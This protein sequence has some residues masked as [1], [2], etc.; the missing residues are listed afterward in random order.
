MGMDIAALGDPAFQVG[1][2]R[3]WV[4]DREFPD[5]MDYWDGNWLDVTAYCQYP[6]ANVW[7]QGTFVRTDELLD[8]LME[9]ERLHATLTGQAALNC[10]E[11]NLHVELL[12]LAHGQ[13]TLKVA[14]TSDHLSQRH[15]FEEQIDQ[16]YLP[17]IISACRILLQR[18]PVVGS[19]DSEPDNGA[20]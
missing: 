12:A 16:S 13:V 19:R 17:G 14:L 15:E 4:Q 6:G 20:P 9:C 8:F 3:V 11:P 1:G 5:A 18:F 2:L 7:H 10:M